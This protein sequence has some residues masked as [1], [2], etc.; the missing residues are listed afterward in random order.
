[1]A[2]PWVRVYTEHFLSI[3]VY[4]PQLYFHFSDEK[5]SIKAER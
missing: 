2:L 5:T 4:S 1:M 3:L